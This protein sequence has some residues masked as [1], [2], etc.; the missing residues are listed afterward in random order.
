MLHKDFFNRRA[1]LLAQLDKD[2]IAIIVAAPEV[3]RNG[4]AHYSYRPNSDLYY[5][6]G[7]EEPQAV[8]IF[9]PGGDHGDFILFNQVK[10]K[11]KEQWD[12]YI[13]G[14]EEACSVYGADKAFPIADIREELPKLML[15]RTKIFYDLGKP[16]FDDVVIN[17]ISSLRRKVRSG[18]KA[19][20]DIVS[21]DALLHEQRLIKSEFEIEQM[22]HA[23]N[24]SVIAHKK[25]M[26]LCRPGLSEYHLAAEIHYEFQK[27]GCFHPAYTS[28]VGA[29]KN[30][31]ILHYI[32]NNCEL[33]DGDLVLIDAG[34]EYNNY[35]ADL[36]RTFP[37]NGKYSEEQ[38]LIYELVLNSQKAALEQAKAGACWTAMQTGIVKV[39]TEGLVELGILQG[40][41]ADLIEKKA[42]T[43]FYMH[44]SGHW[45]GLD[46]HDA[47]S[48]KINEDWRTLQAGMVL[49]IE[50]GLYIA[51]NT[52]G[53]DEKWWNIGVRIEDDVLITE[54]GN[55][56]LSKDLPKELADV[57]ALMRSQD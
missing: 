25:A 10:D 14:Q 3:L 36:T 49:T 37:V 56:V 35:A 19:P 53:V 15:G 26:Q 2:S 55:D 6:T 47:G 18:V 17:A 50:P 9:A 12:G 21:V 43:P 30:G 27:H 52:P 48:Y 13:V 46:V 57:E 45:L 11:L 7:F 31:C 40:K 16:H 34:A 42:Y 8:A 32:S 1:K 5:L 51:A 44:N 24:A 28:I 54:S 39:L 29:G 38:K 22:R 20:M 33:Q 23:V 4:D 41:V